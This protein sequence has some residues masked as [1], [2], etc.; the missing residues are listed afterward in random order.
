MLTA[1]TYETAVAPGQ[2]LNGLTLNG[3][4]L[5]RILYKNYDAMVES[6]PEGTRITRDIDWSQMGVELTG[7]KPGEMLPPP[8]R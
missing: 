8:S 5:D 7:R 6:R 1:E 2:L 3:A 4:L